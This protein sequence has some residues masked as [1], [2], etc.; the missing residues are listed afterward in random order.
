M[1]VLLIPLVKVCV[2]YTYISYGLQKKYVAYSHSFLIVRVT[3][4]VYHRYRLFSGVQFETFKM[5]QGSIPVLRTSVF[6]LFRDFNGFHPCKTSAGEA[7]LPNWYTFCFFFVKKFS[8]IFF[9][10]QIQTIKLLQGSIRAVNSQFPT[11]LRFQRFSR[12]QN[13]CMQSLHF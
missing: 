10:A 1:G 5:L 2:K 7:H 8:L 3:F 6:R 9:R 4:F 11:F 13:L 12:P